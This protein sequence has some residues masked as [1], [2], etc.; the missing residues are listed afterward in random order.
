[1]GYRSSHAPFRHD[2]IG[3]FVAALFIGQPAGE[4]DMA[5]DFDVGAALLSRACWAV[6]IPGVITNTPPATRFAH[7]IE[8]LSGNYF[9]KNRLPGEPAGGVEDIH[10]HPVEPRQVRVGLSWKF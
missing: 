8:L 9:E 6:A 7:F 4:W 10:F 2:G 1:V 3:L 5:Y